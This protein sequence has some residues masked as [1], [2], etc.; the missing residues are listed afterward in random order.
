MAP[1]KK[2]VVEKPKPKAPP[3]K[4]PF[5]RKELGE[6]KKLLLAR[7]ATLAGDIKQMEDQT[8]KRS[9]R[10]ASGDLSSMPIHMADVGTA[11]FEQEFTIGRIESESDEIYEIDEALGRIEDGIYGLCEEC[12]DAIPVP[13]LKAIPYTRLC[14]ACQRREEIRKG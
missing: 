13:R 4:S 11:Q 1:K 9:S 3:K 14:V 5:G 8:L 7:Q 2:V 10:E 12:D 6:F